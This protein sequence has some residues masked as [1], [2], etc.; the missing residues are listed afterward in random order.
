[1]DAPH[2]RTCLLALAI[3]THDLDDFFAAAR[4]L[5]FRNLSIID[6]TSDSTCPACDSPRPGHKAGC[7]LGLAVYRAELLDVPRDGAMEQPDRETVTKLVRSKRVLPLTVA[8]VTEASKPRLMATFGGSA[9]ILQCSPGDLVWYPSDLAWYVAAYFLPNG[10]M[11]GASHKWFG[12]A[13][14]VTGLRVQIHDELLLLRPIL[15]AT[16]PEHVA[17]RIAVSLCREPDA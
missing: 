5:E 7:A 15:R 1:M 14:A 10:R 3:G 16:R 8:E 13:G 11:H 4:E 17:D 6:G 12:Q 9:S 2:A